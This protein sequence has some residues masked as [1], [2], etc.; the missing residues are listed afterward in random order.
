MAA[1]S[2]K[3]WDMYATI[4]VQYP[5]GITAGEKGSGKM[6]KRWKR[7]IVAMILLA[8]LIANVIPTAHA[9]SPDDVKYTSC[10]N[11][12]YQLGLFK[13]TGMK[14]DNTPE[15]AL[16]KYPSR[17]EALVMLI[18]LLGEEEKAK[19]CT[20]PHPFTDVSGWAEC[21][22]AYGYAKGYCKGTSAT[23]FGPNAKANAKMFVTFVL[24]AL[25]YDDSNFDFSYDLACRKG[26]EIGLFEPGAYD[27][28][29]FR[30]DDCAYLCYR[31]LFTT[32]K[33]SGKTL[34]EVLVE[35]GAVDKV[36]AEQ[37]VPGLGPDWILTDQDRHDVYGTN[38]G[39]G[40]SRTIETEYNVNRTSR[41]TQSKVYSGS[42]SLRQELVFEYDETGKHLLAKYETYPYSDSD[43]IISTVNTYDERG[44]ILTSESAVG[45]FTKAGEVRTLESQGS[46]VYENVYDDQWR[47]KQVNYT[48]DLYSRLEKNCY[49]ETGTITYDLWG[50]VIRKE[51]VKKY[52]A[53]WLDDDTELETYTYD[54]RGNLTL[55]EVYSNGNLIK[56]IAHIYEYSGALVK[57]ETVE[58]SDWLESG[59]LMSGTKTVMQYDKW[60]NP[61]RK[62]ET[63]PNYFI[64]RETTWEYRY[65]SE[66]RILESREIEETFNQ[67]NISYHLAGL[68]EHEYVVTTQTYNEFGNVTE[69]DRRSYEYIEEFDHPTAEIKEFMKKDGVSCDISGYRGG[70]ITKKVFDYDE[71]HKCVRET[72]YYSTWERGP[73]ETK[74]P[75]FILNFEPTDRVFY[76]VTLPGVRH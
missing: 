65:G 76:R 37:A 56:R 27:Y 69:V 26:A 73:A 47:L 51:S 25:G 45:Y 15:Y 31:A 70:T 75:E 9:E 22:V 66:G 57:T 4:K 7:R 11:E 13:G 36:E 43:Y 34:L 29:P 68:N 30:R 2:L 52:D 32:L 20:E 19:A 17:A 71:Y 72:E 48:A 14:E 24:R 3:N 74:E 67:T 41:R 8:V 49:L 61:I 46:K 64:R 1:Q 28:V 54:D 63:G 40:T 33:Q 58:T 21:Y 44:N 5:R 50:N 39:D 60:G 42:G 16:A 55:Y 35:K 62:T 12:L 59:V 18:R 38:V 23:T 53:T 10:A 6:R